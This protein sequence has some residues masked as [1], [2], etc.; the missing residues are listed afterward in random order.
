MTEPVQAQTGPQGPNPDGFNAVVRSGKTGELMQSNLQAQYYEQAYRGNAF[1]AYSSAQLLSLAG[2]AMT[3]LQLWNGSTTKNLVLLRWAVQVSV[4]SATLTGIAM[5]VGTGQ[6]SAPTSQTAASKV[7]NC[8]IGGAAPAATA[9]NAG[10]FAVAPASQWLMMHNTAAIA[11]TG[12]DA[13]FDDF[14]GSIIIP[15]NGY[16]ALCALGA[17]SAAAAVTSSLM[18][19][20]VP[21]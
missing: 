18:W 14:A 11:T 2:T 17:A 4:T 19:M 10:T 6:T 12:E 1:M 15:P 3:G 13:E 7:S 8:L 5:G 9:L 20:E 16:A 21:V